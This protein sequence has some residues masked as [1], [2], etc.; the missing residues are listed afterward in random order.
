MENEDYIK[1]ELNRLIES[2]L[3]ML[4]ETK[5]LWANKKDISDYELG[6]FHGMILVSK[7]FNDILHNFGSRIGLEKSEEKKEE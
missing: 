5:R 7:D 4:A 2:N 6:R 3:I 1:R